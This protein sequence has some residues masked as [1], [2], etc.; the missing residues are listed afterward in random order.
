[1]R[2]TLGGAVA[3]AGQLS[4]P[5]GLTL[6]DAAYNAF[7]S[8]LQLISLIGAV[9]MISLALL[10]LTLL[11]HVDIATEP[12]QHPESEPDSLTTI[13]AGIQS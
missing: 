7:V 2:E 11:R 12:E 10:T 9:V 6:L 5:L 13:S 3:A 8:G 4:G 1:V